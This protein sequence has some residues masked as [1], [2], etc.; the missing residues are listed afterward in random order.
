VAVVV[1]LA[2][3]T[4]AALL[5]RPLP[6]WDTWRA[7]SVLPMVLG[8]VIASAAIGT[9][10]FAAVPSPERVSQTYDA[11]FHLN[12]AQSIVQ[13]GDASSLHLYRLTHPTQSTAFYPAVWH[14]LV[15]LTVQITGVPVTVATN[16]AWIATA[17]PVFAFGCAFTAAVLFGGTAFRGEAPA[18]Q[19]PVIAAVSALLASTFV[20]FPYLLL[21]FGTLY[22][23]GLAYT[24]L[25]VGLALCAAV[26][27][28]PAA[29]PW[30]PES[31]APRW[32]TGLLLLAWLGAAAFTHP[33]SVV[34]LVALAVPMLVAWFASRMRALSARG[35]RERRRAQ[36][37]TLLLV[38]AVLL[39][40]VL[41][42]V[43][44][45]HYYDVASRPISDHLNGPPAR[46]REGFAQA[47]LQGLLTTSLVSPAQSALPPSVLLAAVA[48]A[49]LVAMAL[50]PG[51]RWAAVGYLLVVL[52]YAFAAGSDSDLAKLATGL[53]DKDK[54]RILAM[55]PTIG[56]PV[57]AWTVTVGAFEA[58]A[59]LR[60]RRTHDREPRRRTLAAAAAVAAL[61]VAV[62]TWVGPA[63]GGVSSAIGVVF[64]LPR[65][66]KHGLLL[67][68]DQSV[69]LSQVGRF[70]PAGQTIIDDPWNGSALAWALGQRQTLFPHLGGYWGTER[71][72]IALHLDRY[73]TDPRVCTAVRHLDLHWVLADPQR[74]WNNRSEAKAFFGIDRAVKGDGVRLVA[75]SGT[76]GLYRLT[77]CWP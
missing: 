35:E 21:D 70:V 38:V 56:V 16:A 72:R 29:S 30:Q 49:G 4:L 74:L 32:R 47:L 55:L 1:L 59:G 58:V 25:P 62:V 27:A 48:L 12:A 24:T 31:P 45:Y 67:D 26:L 41:A 73:A 5:G 54:F 19:R 9:I 66:D 33:R 7:G 10:A 13:T 68:E 53:W 50:R 20:A 18:L 46:A 15:A 39:L 2:L 40:L 3:R 63:L 34:A 6:A 14:S 52:L 11:V 36:R 8:A 28:W 69:L 77:A 76:A 65:S 43:F 61:L 51:L 37:Y 57:V 17:G 64:S 23:N 71:K 75:S 44:I 42:G 60:H 22:P